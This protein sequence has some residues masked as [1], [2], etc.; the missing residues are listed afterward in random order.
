VRCVDI[1]ERGTA[2]E[3]REAIDDSVPQQAPRQ[4]LEAE[5]RQREAARARHE[6]REQRERPITAR[7]VV[8][9]ERLH[10]VRL[11]AQFEV[12]TLGP[13][14]IGRRRREVQERA[15]LEPQEPREVLFRNEL[16]E[17]RLGH[18]GRH[19]A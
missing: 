17:R 1:Q 11:V 5:P 2:L 19:R 18:G 6:L 7:A 9:Q 8:I 3:A 14:R 15:G 13:G 16:V 4:V 12:A 10:E